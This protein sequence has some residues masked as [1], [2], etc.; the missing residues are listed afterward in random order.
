[1]ADSSDPVPDPQPVEPRYELGPELARG[2]LGRV[3]LA[4][5]R[6]LGGRD[7]AIKQ[8][9]RIT[10]AT[11][12]RFRR[13]ALLTARLQHP[14]IV[15]LYD[16]GDGAEPFY[17]MKLV[18]GRTL[19]RAIAEAAT[20]AARLGLLP[21]VID[22]ADAVSYAHSRGVIHRDIKPSNV[23]IGDFGETVV[24]DWGLAKRLDDPDDAARGAVDDDGA[25][26]DELTAAGDVLG[27]PAYMAPE[28]A[29]GDPVDERADV[30]AIGALLYHVLSGHKPYQGSSRQ[31]VLVEVLTRPPIAVTSHVDVA[32]DLVAIVDRAMARD[33][34]QRYRTGSALSSDLRRF[35]TGRMVQAYS[36][37]ASLLVRRWLRR[38]RGAVLV[39]AAL[40]AVLVAG[41][42]ASVRTVVRERNL[43]EAERERATRRSEALLIGQARAA[44]ANDP[45]E[46]VAWLAELG[47]QL[48]RHRREVQDLVVEARARGVAR[49]VMVAHRRALKAIATT[50]DGAVLATGSDDGT[51]RVWRTDADGVRRPRLVLRHG[52]PITRMALARD[53][54]L[55]AS[56]TERG[57]VAWWDLD[58]PDGDV[59]GEAA[60][61]AWQH[62]GVVYALRMTADG[63]L[64]T[65][66]EDGDVWAGRRGQA[67][68]L[69][70][71]HASPMYAVAVAA[72]GAIAAGGADGVVD[73][74]S[75]SGQVR[76]LRHPAAVVELAFSPDQRWLVTLCSDL[77]IRLWPTD[78]GEPRLLGRSGA[79]PWDVAF[80][81]DGDR[82]AV[83][84]Q[85]GT[86]TTYR[87][88]ASEVRSRRAHTGAGTLVRWS[89]DGAW[90][91]TGGDDGLVRLWSDAGAGW[92]LRGHHGSIQALELSADSRW[93]LSGDQDGAMRR[94][95]LPE[96]DARVSPL[97]VGVVR[98]VAVAADDAVVTGGADGAVW[99]VPAT[100]APAR[101]ARHAH[102]VDGV[103]ISAD[104]AVVVSGDTGGTV[105]VHRPGVDS[106]VLG[107]EASGVTSVAL[108]AAGDEVAVATR[109]GVIGRWQLGS[110]RRGDLAGHAGMVT[111]VV[112]TADGTLVSGGTDGTVRRWPPGASRSDPL[113]PATASVARVAAAGDLIAAADAD[114]AVMVWHGGGAGRVLH[115]HDGAASSVAVSPD[116]RAILS[117]SWDQSAR[118]TPIDGSAAVE[119]DGHGAQVNAGAFLPRGDLVVTVADDGA[120]RVFGLDGALV[121]MLRVHEGFATRLVVSRRGLVVT[122]G[123]DGSVARWRGGPGGADEIAAVEA[124]AE[125]STARVGVD[126]AVER[127]R[128]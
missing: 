10:P 12:K 32:P 119:L 115:R 90:I 1:M 98:A 88:T 41:G 110:G 69:L 28:Q 128:P 11:L 91:A 59:A 13:E 125:V 103:A 89:R 25:G 76:T 16:M 38:R 114:G 105:M 61:A 17:A 51:V 23:L 49:D 109:G 123:S 54:R 116:Q 99:L 82:V 121:R 124:L 68:T 118:L 96:D 20:P 67:P 108:S 42:V 39:V 31:A 111:H 120:V 50:D 29:A 79:T 2:G 21:H 78:G 87:I 126:V 7:V 63:R 113:V 70:A 107:R 95:R 80:A 112:Y 8:L 35:Q 117:T 5:D 93:L 18:A 94:W 86:L 24:V 65:A 14:A 45:T 37:P 104:G 127:R 33:P 106:R 100:G 66:G 43:A 57:A 85:G 27:T 48:G 47:D 74:R 58:R 83:I 26:C 71:R 6:R 77:G 52:G 22:V 4:R 97:H 44:L 55:L 84:D 56:A 75:A 101:L 46:T 64:V 34:A 81:P 3:L 30:Y 15:P 53:G 102:S 36:Y 122:A 19:E 72:S 9:L 62:R 60:E 73:L 40:L 92:T